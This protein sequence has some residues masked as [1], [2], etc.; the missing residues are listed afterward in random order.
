MANK[1]RR[2]ITISQHLDERLSNIDN[3]SGLIE[4]LLKEYFDEEIANDP[5]VLMNKEREFDIEID[6]LQK[7]R[8][9]VKDKLI[10][11][12]EKEKER[13]R[14]KALSERQLERK[15]KA[16]KLQLLWR[17]EELN[18]EQYW[19]EMDRLKEEYGDEKA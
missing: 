4:S 12:R 16:D 3:A 8:E 17:N 2:L 7:K 10:L 1:A 5:E 11:L 18:D 9:H 13:E 14:R 19:Q 15:E 6:N